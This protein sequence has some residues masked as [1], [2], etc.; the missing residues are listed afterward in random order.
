[1]AGETKLSIE[2]KKLKEMPYFYVRFISLAIMFISDDL[3]RIFVK[4]PALV[5]ICI[6]AGASLLTFAVFETVTVIKM[7][8]KPIFSKIPFVIWGLFS[9]CC[10]ISSVI[11][12]I[13]YNVILLVVIFP[14]CIIAGQEKHFFNFC[15]FSCGGAIIVDIAVSIIFF[16]LIDNNLSL[17]LS[18]LLPILLCAIAWLILNQKKFYTSLFVFFAVL[19]AAMI[20]FSA[21]SGGRTG[22][23]TMLA[24]LLFFTA[25]LLV[26]FISAKKSILYKNSFINTFIILSVVVLIAVTVSAAIFIDGKTEVPPDPAS[27]E[28]MDSF[29]KFVTSVENGNLFSNRGMIWKYTFKNAKMFGNGADFYVGS[30]YLT[31]DQNSAHNSYLAILGHCGIPAFILFMIFC[32]YMLILSVRYCLGSR[33]LYIFPFTVLVNFFTASITED[34]I[35]MYSPRVSY[36]M[37]FC[38][39]AYL[40]ITAIKQ[41]NKSISVTKAK[42]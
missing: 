18:S 32:I 25:A 4:T 11:N 33:R 38:A 9:L 30:D 3:I 17:C 7:K 12:G 21:V 13:S 34:F 20:F 23:L 35:F 10:I 28:N 31:P 1:M 19:C 14:L 29:E 16:P 15:L 37:F 41:S 26:K 27:I 5:P 24:T 8:K 2:L 39:C 6:V 40:S 42:I 36:I 22:F